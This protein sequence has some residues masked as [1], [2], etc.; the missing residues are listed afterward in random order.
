MEKVWIRMKIYS[1]KIHIK[2]STQF[3]YYTSVYTCTYLLVKKK[4]NQ[5]NTGQS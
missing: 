4:T 2:K 5:N 3:F 1:S